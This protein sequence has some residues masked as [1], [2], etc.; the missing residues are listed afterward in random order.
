MEAR[1]CRS[2]WNSFL[3]VVLL[4][5]AQIDEL[6]SQKQQQLP[7]YFQKFL[8][9]LEL[10]GDYFSR[11]RRVPMCQLRFEAQRSDN[12]IQPH[13]T[14]LLSFDVQAASDDL[15]EQL[16][17]KAILEAEAWPELR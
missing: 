6:K 10:R 5:Q 17:A 9:L 11:G 12:C 16:A 8:Q 7:G 15:A 14:M 13:Q 1:E 2:F 3:C 4:A